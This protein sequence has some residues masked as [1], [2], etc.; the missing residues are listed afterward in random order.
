LALRRQITVLERRLPGDRPRIL[1]EYDMPPDLH[2]RGL[3]HQQGSR[4][5]PDAAGRWEGEAMGAARAG[6]VC[7]LA[8]THILGPDRR[9]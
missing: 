6:A 8:M 2:G 1:R 3:R 5:G 7:R 9:W 4:P